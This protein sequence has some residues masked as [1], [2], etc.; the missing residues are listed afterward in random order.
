MFGI[1]EVFSLSFPSS[2]VS[3]VSSSG[4]WWGGF[5]G[6][7]GEGG[8][9]PRPPTPASPLWVEDEEAGSGDSLTLFVLG[10]LASGSWFSGFCRLL[11]PSTLVP[12]W[13][14]NSGRLLA[15]N[16][17]LELKRTS[18]PSFLMIVAS[19]TWWFKAVMWEERILV[20]Q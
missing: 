4:P 9:K 13:S 12:C 3:V 16:S 18:T 2:S 1:V 10:W 17:F 5:D 11:V 19:V 14:T 6:I 20:F 15:P 8:L 7:W